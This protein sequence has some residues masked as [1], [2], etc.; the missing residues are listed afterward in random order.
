VLYE[1]SDGAVN[2]GA[3]H[4]ALNLAAL[5]ELPVVFLVVNN[6]YGLGA[7]VERASAEP[8]GGLHDGV[9]VVAVDRS[10]CIRNADGAGGLS[11][12]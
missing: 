9:E 7:A 4:E 10:P 3:W 8:V 2:I 12:A 1:L 6:G 5:W 11:R